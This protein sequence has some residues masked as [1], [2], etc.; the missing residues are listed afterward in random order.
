MAYEKTVAYEIVKSRLLKYV[1][2]DKM[3]SYLGHPTYIMQDGQFFYQR[4]VY[5]I[6]P[7]PYIISTSYILSLT[8][9]PFAIK[10]FPIYN[11]NYFQ[12]ISNLFN[13]FDTFSTK[14]FLFHIHSHQII[15]FIH[16]PFIQSPYL[17]F[18]THI[19]LFI[20]F[21]SICIILRHCSFNNFL[22]R[23]CCRPISQLARCPAPKYNQRL[24]DRLNLKSKLRHFHRFSPNFQRGGDKC[25]IWT[26]CSTQSTL[27]L[28]GFEMKQYI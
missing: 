21:P 17:P 15:H 7:F 27:K 11:F 12:H 5:Y 14:I 28:S 4:S 2:H 18:L 19:Y 25:D 1:K 20:I 23:I 22:Y 3:A 24:E 26:R 9:F 6:F 13:Q 10:Y 8:L 16:F